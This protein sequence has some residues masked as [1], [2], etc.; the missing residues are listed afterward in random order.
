[1]GAERLLGWPAAE[2]LGTT[3]DV[4]FTPGDRL[5]G[6]PQ[7]ERLQAATAGR[8]TDER[9]QQR[10]NGERF[11]ASGLLM[12]LED[13]DR[14]FV[15]ILRDN[16]EKHLAEERLRQSEERQ[17]ILL[18]ELQHRTRNLLGVVI[19]IAK[20]TLRRKPP[21]DVF[22]E[23]FIHRLR[24]LGRVQTLIGTSDYRYVDLRALIGA[25][26][27]AYHD[28]KLSP[29]RVTLSGPKITLSTI[30]AQTLGLA[31]HELTTNAVKHGALAGDSGRLAV[32]WRLEQR[33]GIPW[34]VLTWK[35]NGVNIPDSASIGFGYGRELI[36]RALP[37][38][39][40]AETRLSFGPDGLNCSIAVPLEGG[41]GD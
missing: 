12:R 18:A 16:T 29:G 7:F 20:Q 10:K 28:E 2:I 9:W 13:A 4:I 23:E 41:T 6:V 34:V 32:D 22:E 27:E 36:E 37:Y 17:T 30:A 21:L 1:V 8:A 19:S 11:W 38:Q 31:I 5:A 33:K 25:E 40:D 14:G 3:A 26:L 35:E 15:K 39:L 24:A